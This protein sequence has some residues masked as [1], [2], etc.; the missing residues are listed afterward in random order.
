MQKAVISSC[1]LK[2]SG[3]WWKSEILFSLYLSCILYSVN[4]NNKQFLNSRLLF[5]TLKL[6]I[7]HYIL[8]TCHLPIPSLSISFP[9]P[10]FFPEVDTALEENDNQ[11]V[12]LCCSLKLGCMKIIND[13]VTA[14]LQ[15]ETIRIPTNSWLETEFGN[16]MEMTGRKLSKKR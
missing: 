15:W 7:N 9:L 10:H 14:A 4:N 11:A 5:R 2:N 13:A 12:S 8:F 1:L 6:F 3:I 16:I